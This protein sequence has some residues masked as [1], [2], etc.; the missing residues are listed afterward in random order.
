MWVN[1]WAVF[2]WSTSFHPVSPRYQWS[3]GERSAISHACACVLGDFRCVR[4]WTVA[5][6]APLPMGLSRQEFWSRLTCSSPGDLPDPRIEPA[7]LKPTCIGKRVLY[8]YQHLGNPRKGGQN[9]G[10]YSFPNK[11]LRNLRKQKK[12][13]K[14]E[15][16]GRNF[17]QGILAWMQRIP[18]KM[19]PEGLWQQEA[20]IPKQGH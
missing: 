4:L 15:G 1:V 12:K 2:L 18:E 8:H 19:F 5:L 7:T 6:Q 3:L 10:N 20:A 17:P 16:G 9:E 14:K 11:A 13:K